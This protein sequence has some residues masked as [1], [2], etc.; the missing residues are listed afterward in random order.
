MTKSKKLAQA[1]TLRITE[2]TVKDL[3]KQLERRAE[4]EP[5]LKGYIEGIAE[6]LENT[7]TRNG[8]TRSI[9]YGTLFKSLYSYIDE[10]NAGQLEL[11]KEAADPE[12]LSALL[13]G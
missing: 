1:I 10:N 6:Q 3:V 11:L 9:S 7:A 8:K 12:K 4:K 2:N 13:Q 5:F